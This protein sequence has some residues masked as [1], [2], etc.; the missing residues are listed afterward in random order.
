MDFCQAAYPNQARA[1]LLSWDQSW[2]LSLKAVGQGLPI[3][4][5]CGFPLGVGKVKCQPGQAVSSQESQAHAMEIVTC[6]HMHP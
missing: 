4:G 5:L 2:A 1:S 6:E 3:A